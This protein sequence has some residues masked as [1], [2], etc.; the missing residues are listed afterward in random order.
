[1][2]KSVSQEEPAQE[3]AGKMEEKQHRGAPRAH[4]LTA[5]WT[6]VRVA[7]L[8]L[9]SPCLKTCSPCLYPK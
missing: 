3:D 7:W 1:M 5:A 2:L 9:L 6:P 4:E 8:C